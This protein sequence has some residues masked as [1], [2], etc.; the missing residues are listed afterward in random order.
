MK[1]LAIARANLVRFV[2]DRSNVFFV[3]I[4]PIGIVLL[5]GAQFGGEPTTSIAVA[6]GSGDTVA[7]AIVEE[8]R[9]NAEIDVVEME[10]ADDVLTDVER[11][12]MPAGVNIP[13]DIGATIAA[14]TTAEVGFVSRPDG[15]GPRLRSVVDQAVA[16][17]TADASAE[18]FVVGLGV[19]T[20]QSSDLV[21]TAATRVTPVDV[22]TLTS[23][24]SVFAGVEGR[25]DIGAS[26]QLVLFMFLTSLSGS[27]ELIKSRQLGV[28]RRML[29]TPTG[30]GS[31]IG[32]EGLGRFGVSMAQG[33][34]IV[35]ATILIFRVDWGDPVATA[36]VILTFAAVGA[37]A[38][39]TF[40]T[41]FRNDQQAGSV[42][43][44]AGLGLAALGGCMLPLELFNPTL[45]RIA[46]LTPHAWANDAFAEILRRGGSVVDILPELGVL[47][48]YAAVLLAFASWRMRPVM[49]GG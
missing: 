41:I 24:D 39:M 5:I 45:Q 28:T 20:E 7:E 32:G 27:A 43:V 9:S 13:E 23:G 49:T 17:A 19:P 29:S 40:G 16:S 1:L 21:A 11:G 25:F 15:S 33:L 35:A 34:Y 30:S 12:N 42:G 26:S 10:S 36:A 48:A 22:T 31:I 46:H 38:A 4:L 8:L 14:G 6:G 47:V 18:R 44:I 37:G 3:F 2:R